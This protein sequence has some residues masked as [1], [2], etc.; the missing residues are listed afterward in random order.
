MATDPATLVYD[1]IW[2]TLEAHSDFAS[3]VLAGDRIKFNDA[4]PRDPIKDNVLTADKPEVRLI[5]ESTAFHF[6]SSSSSTFWIVT[7]NLQVATGELRVTKKLFPVMWAAARALTNW[8]TTL[9]AL[10]WNSK[11][12]VH[13]ARPITTSE[14]VDSVLMNRGIIGWS[15]IWAYEVHMHFTTSDMQT[16]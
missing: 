7:Y 11:V 4:A 2:A 15:S 8:P 3:L 6:E 5:G 14:G 9:R 13:L 1:S 12:F 10:T 16:V